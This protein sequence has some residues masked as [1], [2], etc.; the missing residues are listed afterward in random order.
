MGESLLKPDFRMPNNVEKIKK[1]GGR[2]LSDYYTFVDNIEYINDNYF[3][4]F[5][6][7]YMDD[8]DII[9]KVLDNNFNNLRSLFI[10]HVTDMI[11]DG[12]I[13][14]DKFLSE[15]SREKFSRMSPEERQQ[16]Q[17]KAI[18]RTLGK[19]YDETLDS[20]LQENNVDL[21]RCR[22]SRIGLRLFGKTLFVS[23]SGIEIDVDKYIEAYKSFIAADESKTRKDHERAAMAINRFFNGVE[24][25]LEELSRY[26]ILEHGIVK[27]RQESVNLEDYLRLGKRTV[28]VIKTDE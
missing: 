23:G 6:L 5:R 10:E 12:K 4:L 20:Y 3:M 17:K 18:G 9:L 19:L 8:I 14:I 27:V 21:M 13:S 1:I 25:T 24:I 26:F 28:R 22:Y 7:L 16:G 2:A 11:K 15:Y